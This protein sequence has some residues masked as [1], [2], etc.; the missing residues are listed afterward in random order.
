MYKNKTFRLTSSQVKLDIC[1][2]FYPT[3][4]STYIGTETWR[5]YLYFA[6]CDRWI[7]FYWNSSQIWLTY[8]RN[9]KILN[10]QCGQ[11]S[12]QQGPT[13]NFIT[14]YNEAV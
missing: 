13:C 10:E 12:R 11:S 6:D 8:G 14:E 4:T 1:S 7:L 5:P 3:A 2:L 9:L